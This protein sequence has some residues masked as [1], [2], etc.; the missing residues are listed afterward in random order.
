[1]LSKISNLL[2]RLITFKSLPILKSYL[3]SDASLCTRMYLSFSTL[4]NLIKWL[5]NFSSFFISEGGL[6][7][8]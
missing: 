4:N 8:L 6:K 7:C 2:E 3:V 1:M 5:Y